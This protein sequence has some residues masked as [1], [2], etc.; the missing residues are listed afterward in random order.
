MSLAQLSSLQGAAPPQ[1]PHPHLTDGRPLLLSV[2]PS[3]PPALR[4]PAGSWAHFSRP[5][6]SKG[7]HRRWPR[8]PLSLFS[9]NPRKEKWSQL[10][11]LMEKNS[12]QIGAW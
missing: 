4:E 8:Q 1:A 5:F 6:T 7:N 10:Y 2:G 9:R 11:I 12:V 3:P